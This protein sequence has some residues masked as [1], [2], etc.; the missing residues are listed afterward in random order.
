MNDNPEP[1]NCDVRVIDDILCS[2][3]DNKFDSCNDTKQLTSSVLLRT[4]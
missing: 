4:N 1:G 2:Q 3:S